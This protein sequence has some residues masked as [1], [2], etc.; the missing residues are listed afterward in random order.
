[1]GIEFNT[2]APTPG[3]S[4][5][6]EDMGLMAMTYLPES[7]YTG[8]APTSGRIE[9][10]RIRVETAGQTT[11]VSYCI[12]TIGSGLTASQ[13]YLALFDTSGTRLAITADLSGT[14][15]GTI[16]TK[17]E[18]WAAAATITPGDYFIAVMCN[19]TTPVQFRRCDNYITQNGTKTTPIAGLRIIRTSSTSNTSIP[20][21]VD[22]S[23]GFIVGG[24]NPWLAIY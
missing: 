12:S 22:F 1:M 23:S 14:F 18:A 9:M 17:T 6:P 24:V 4:W 16:G 3:Y 10:S 2:K 8:G 19:G 20:A 15:A 11:G 5:T 13:S 7:T 21:S